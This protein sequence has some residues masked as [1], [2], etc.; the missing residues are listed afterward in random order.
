[1]AVVKIWRCRDHRNGGRLD[2]SCYIDCNGGLSAA[3]VNVPI[4]CRFRFDAFE[5]GTTRMAVWGVGDSTGSDGYMLIVEK[6]GDD[7]RPVVRYLDT[8][9][10]FADIALRPDCLY[11]IRL[12]VASGTLYLDVYDRWG[13]PLWEA[14]QA[15]SASG[16]L[17]SNDLFV[18]ATSND[19]DDPELNLTGTLFDLM[20][21]IDGT[22]YVRL[23]FYEGYDASGSGTVAD[24]Y[25]NL[26]ATVISPP[27]DFWPSR[28]DISDEVT[29]VGKLR[30]E[31]DTWGVPRYCSLELTCRDTLNVKAHDVIE[32]EAVKTSAVNWLYRVERVEERPCGLQKLHCIDAL[33]DLAHVFTDRFFTIT[34][35]FTTAR[36]DWW[37]NYAPVFTNGSNY[38][39]T[40]YHYDASN[41]SRRWVSLG[42][43]L[44]SVVAYLQLDNLIEVNLSDLLDADSPLEYSGSPL[45]YRWFAFNLY[46]LI[47][48]GRSRR[49]DNDSISVA[50]LLRQIAFALRFGWL[51]DDS[52]LEARPMTTG[53]P[54]LA[55]NSML[56]FRSAVAK[57]HWPHQVR[58]QR[59]QS[60]VNSWD[61]WDNGD[62]EE[63]AFH[64]LGGSYRAL[65]R[66][67]DITCVAILEPRRH[68]SVSNALLDLSPDVL[69]Q[70]ADILDA[71]Y[72]ASRT[73]ESVRLPFTP[74]HDMRYASKVDDV[75]NMTT[76]LKQER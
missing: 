25:N 22:D 71:R 31:T 4:R 39:V 69:A 45:D 8:E 24:A 67:K 9:T 51:L 29:A 47:Y 26:D 62:T 64:N 46:E 15:V 6:S 18:G 72:G 28:T 16:T 52:D 61:A 43:I 23:V 74:S 3:C 34:A 57:E 44:Q 63:V 41:E 58:Q 66:V 42:Y 32:I 55:D 27:A 36:Q 70:L 35:A 56:A 75:N 38:S 14:G 65:N 40:E 73:T 1:M 48:A 54:A 49:D 60:G 50:R 13:N 20:Y 11:D 76:E 7:Y 17:S 21:T 5:A 19:I 2:G 33:A 37:S 10:A 59:L 68:D 30:R 12:R 53:A